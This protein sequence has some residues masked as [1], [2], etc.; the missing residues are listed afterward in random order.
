MPPSTRLLHAEAA[1]ATTPLLAADKRPPLSN[2]VARPPAE[3]F[4]ELA[5]RTLQALNPKRRIKRSEVPVERV[6]RLLERLLSGDSPA[7]VLSSLQLPNRRADSTAS[8]SSSSS[9]PAQPNGT[10]KRASSPPPPLALVARKTS[11]ALGSPALPPIDENSTG[12]SLIPALRYLNIITGGGAHLNEFV[13]T[14]LEP[15]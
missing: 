8:H 13:R 12:D 15:E 9:S 14:V 2:G 11:A 6:R 7:E 1:T 5:F 3:N 10:S 4:E